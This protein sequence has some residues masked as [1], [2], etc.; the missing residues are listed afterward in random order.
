MPPKRAV[1]NYK[2][3]LLSFLGPSKENKLNGRKIREKVFP[4]V[5]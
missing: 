1:S 3:G 5:F 2:L 4:G